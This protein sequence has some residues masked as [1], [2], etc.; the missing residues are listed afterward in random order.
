[1]TVKAREKFFYASGAVANG[2]KADGFTFFLLFFYSNVIGLT[3]GLA[4]LAIFIALMI[5]AFT[6]PLMGAI[7]DR[8]NHR[9]GRRHPYFLLGIIPMGLSY[10][11]LFS[12]QSS[13]QLSQQQLFF[14]MLAFTALTRLGMTIFDVPHRSLGSEMSRSYTE[15]TSIFAAREMFGWAGGLFNAF[16]AYTVFFKDTPEYIPG[17]QNPEPWI[18]FGMTGAGLMCISV[19]VT[20]FGTLQ[21]RNSSIQTETSFD[22]TSITSQIYIALK[23]K[24]F[25]IFFFGYLFIAVSWGLNSS[26]QLY[27]N[28]YFW[29]FKSIMIA[30][31]LGIYALSTFTAFLLVPRLVLYIEKRSI[32]LI[33]IAFAALIPPIP[34]ILYLNDLLPDS[35]SWDL[36][37]VLAPFIYLGNTCLSSSAIVRESMLG[38][39]S[40]EVELESKLGQQGLMYASSSLIGKLNTG[41][42]IL[43]AGLALEFIGFPQ[44]SEILPNAD[45]VFSLA[46]VQGPFVAILMIIPFGI[47]SFYSIDRQ[48]HKKI[49]DQLAVR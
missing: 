36:F 42:G 13:W 47:F 20:Y 39:I 25:L 5:D 27:M 28:T 16:L 10:F 8:T 3:P 17:T 9:L 12:I 1:M 22:L 29:E 14:W 24:S 6:D 4:S 7:S 43:V 19:L 44:G 26:L 45:Q 35:G 34:I 40:D 49:L 48:K 11:M 23:N 46:M 33:A 37:Y 38:D 21:Y 30:S 18:Y 31:F 41:L 2:V 32:L 15:R